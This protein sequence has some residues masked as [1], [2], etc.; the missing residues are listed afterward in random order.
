M[1]SMRWV[2]RAYERACE[3]QAALQEWERAIAAHSVG[4]LSVDALRAIAVKVERQLN[5]WRA[6]PNA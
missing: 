3:A 4:E 6:N 2:E 1:R 5:G